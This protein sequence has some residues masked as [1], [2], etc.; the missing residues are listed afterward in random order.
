MSRAAV[1]NR[2]IVSRSLHVM[3]C[4]LCD[5]IVHSRSDEILITFFTHGQLAI[6]SLQQQLHVQMHFGSLNYDS[7]VFF[8]FF[9]YLSKRRLFA[10]LERV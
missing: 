6:Y 4:A 9:L 8:S 2:T 1:V 7:I 3:H 5:W 10:W